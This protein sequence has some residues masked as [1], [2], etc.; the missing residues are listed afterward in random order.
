MQREND[1]K[2]KFTAATGRSVRKPNID[3]LKQW[4]QQY[5][6]LWDK[7]VGVQQAA[8]KT[9]ARAIM[10]EWANASKKASGT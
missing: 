9:D 5:A 8:G 6:L 10:E 4:Q 2:Q 7:W 1:G 3:E